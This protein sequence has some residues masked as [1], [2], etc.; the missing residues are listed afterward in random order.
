MLGGSAKHAEAAAAAAAGGGGGGATTAGT[1][2]AAYRDKHEQVL[3]IAA[4]DVAAVA[5]YHEWVDVRELFLERLLYQDLDHLLRIDAANVGIEVEDRRQRSEMLLAKAGDGELAAVRKRAGDGAAVATVQ[6]AQAL[7]DKTRSLL[8]EAE[9]KQRLSKAEAKELENDLRHDINTQFGTRNENF[10]LSVYERR[11]GSEVICSNERIMVWPF[12][13]SKVSGDE[14]PDGALKPPIELSK[15]WVKKL[16]RGGPEHA[17]SSTAAEAVFASA[18][19]RC[20]AELPASSTRAGGD[21]NGD[22]RSRE[23]EENG[24]GAAAAAAAVGGAGDGSGAG[25]G[26][27]GGKDASGGGAGREVMDVDSPV[28]PDVSAGG[29]KGRGSGGGGGSDAEQELVPGVPWPEWRRGSSRSIAAGSVEAGAVSP[30]SPADA[31]KLCSGTATPASA[32]DGLSTALPSAPGAKGAGPGT[33]RDDCGGLWFPPSLTPRQ[34]AVVKAAAAELGLCHGSVAGEAGEVRV[35]VWEPAPAL[36]SSTRTTRLSAGESGAAAV[37]AVVPAAPVSVSSGSSNARRGSFVPLQPAPTAPPSATDADPGSDRASSGND[38][39]GGALAATGGAQGARRGSLRGSMAGSK[40]TAE[41]VPPDQPAATT[42]TE[43]KGK[44]GVSAVSSTD[45]GTTTAT[46]TTTTMTSSEGGAS[47]SSSSSSST[48]S[49]VDGIAVAAAPAAAT[50]KAGSKTADIFGG[51]AVYAW[52]EG[53]DAQAAAA[54]EEAFVLPS[55]TPHGAED[56]S[57][58]QGWSVWSRDPQATSP[59]PLEIPGRPRDGGTASPTGGASGLT[60]DSPFASEAL[61]PTTSRGG[62]GGEGAGARGAETTLRERRKNACFVV[63]GAV[64]GVAEEVTEAPEDAET[65]ETRRVVVEVK[66]R[67]H[68]ARN[69]PPLYDQIQLVTYMLMIGAPAGDLVQFVKT[70]AGRGSGRRGAAENEKDS[71]AT[72]G[73]VLVSRVE[74]NCRTYRHR[75]HWEGTILP[76][77]YE[78]ARMVYRFRGDDLRR[79]RYL[80]AAP[81]EQREMLVECC[82]YLENVIPRSSAA[83]ADPSPPPPPL[84]RAPPPMSGRTTAGQD[85]S[86]WGAGT[87]ATSGG[88]A[89]DAQSTAAV[90]VSV[91]AAGKSS[92]GDGSKREVSDEQNAEKVSRNGTGG[93]RGGGGDG[94]G[95]GTAVTAVLSLEPLGDVEAEAAAAAA[96]VAAAASTSPARKKPKVVQEGAVAVDRSDAGQVQGVAD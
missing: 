29:A 49:S 13:G 37:A 82:P 34:Q 84:P 74:L 63:V 73:D 59:P 14:V 3:R 35:V 55:E 85:S 96:A 19:A 61:P 4:S 75:E 48:D 53:P 68:R 17:P 66:N 94:G 72:A 44:N 42:A 15:G 23:G 47:S 51:D 46:T 54:G 91:E 83:A 95:S 89:P 36:P 8:K 52:G 24:T 26:A 76:R 6:D 60:F 43:D 25:G 39:S 28:A 32:G 5:G 67:M 10:A 22:G 38:G 64:D 78:F 16:R 31:P 81:E 69:P 80:L 86:G 45:G 12:P 71:R 21:A 2:A 20:L 90:G 88:A 30:V 50:A 70:G 56:M 33:T 93:G 27:A 77:L 87:P 40:L 1:V 57:D 79:W 62:G 18:V 58:G 41:S 7:R 92:G 9:G 11:S 65:W